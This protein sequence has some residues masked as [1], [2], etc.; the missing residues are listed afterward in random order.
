MGFSF[1]FGF[2]IALGQTG[3]LEG[4]D[5]ASFSSDAVTGSVGTSLANNGSQGEGGSHGGNTGVV[6][7]VGHCGSNGGGNGGGDGGVVDKGVQGGEGGGGSGIEG[8]V[9]G[10]GQSSRVEKNLWVGFRLSLS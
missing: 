6:D 8:I 7:N 3:L 1:S 9:V 10:E 4:T 2:S 5:S